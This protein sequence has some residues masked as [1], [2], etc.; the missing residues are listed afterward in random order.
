MEKQNT[1]AASLDGIQHGGK[2]YKHLAIEPAQ[3]A[4]ANCLGFLEGTAVKYITRH[5]CGIDR[6]RS[7]TDLKKA[8]HYCQMI[9]DM[10]Y[11]VRSKVEFGVAAAISSMTPEA[12]KVNLEK[13]REIAGN[14]SC[15]IWQPEEEKPEPDEVLE[16]AT[17][18]T[19]WAPDGT[20]L[21]SE[22][23][24][25]YRKPD[26]ITPPEHVLTPEEVSELE[27]SL[28]QLKAGEFID[29]GYTQTFQSEPIDITSCGMG[30]GS[31]ASVGIES[32]P[33]VPAQ[34]YR[35]SSL[36][37][38]L[39]N[40]SRK[41][42]YVYEINGLPISWHSKTISG[43]EIRENSGLA[44]DALLLTTVADKAVEVT[45][46]MHLSLYRDGAPVV[47]KFR[48]TPIPPAPKGFWEV[49]TC[50]DSDSGP[51]KGMPIGYKVRW[52][53]PNAAGEYLWVGHYYASEDGL[54]PS[55]A[56][57]HS[58]AEGHAKR[59]NRDYPNG[60]EDFPKCN[61]PESI[62]VANGHYDLAITNTPEERLYKDD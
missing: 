56:W 43:K 5:S 36:A 8:I 35:S 59:M 29:C 46:D 7:I 21:S 54:N 42:G 53:V 9:L 48:T 4:H 57:C 31:K 47:P 40:I 25:K 1:K 15:P 32:A 24:F 16:S 27:K 34:S 23:E 41:K 28:S 3:Y 14:T 6:E 10:E 2:H 51:H 17:S 11:N 55:T 50:I 58:A 18:T 39:S 61:M 12:L 52:S 45:N 30:P 19:T 37:P 22:S 38:N 49:F 44:A 26:P 13:L 33:G 20:V 60:R 62:V